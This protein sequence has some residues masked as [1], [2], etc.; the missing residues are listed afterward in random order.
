MFMLIKF[1]TLISCVIVLG[2]ITTPLLSYGEILG[3]INGTLSSKSVSVTPIFIKAIKDIVSVGILIIGILGILYNGSVNKRSLIYFLIFLGVVIPSI[4]WSLNNNIFIVI[5][6]IRWLVPLFLLGIFINYNIDDSIPGYRKSL[7]FVFIIHILAQ[8]YEFF[9]ASHYYGSFLN[10]FSLRNPGVFLIPST[11]A[12]FSV[13]F[14]VTFINVNRNIKFYLFSFVWLSL[15]L[16]VSGSGILTMLVINIF[17]V[18]RKYLSSFLATM[19][20]I[21][22]G[23]IFIPFFI[24]YSSLLG[25][26]DNYVE[27]SGG[28]RINIFLQLL[29]DNIF[30]SDKFGMGSNTGVIIANNL[31]I[32][33]NAMIVD[34]TF[35]SVLLNLSFLS[36]LLYVCF[37]FILFCFAI[38]GQNNKYIAMVFSLILFSFTSIWFEAYPYNTML[39]LLI[40]GMVGSLRYKNEDLFNNRKIR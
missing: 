2:I 26:G 12:M 10:S 14:Y 20:T 29:N 38:F 25:R 30:I 11:S 32:N 19:G 17:E 23:T 7:V 27:T 36:L 13:I 21:L 34:S 9:F 31:G 6:G 28:E 39:L 15:F 4:V 37:V 16:S 33:A 40:S 24:T 1:K 8:I 35:S 22:S 5:S 3:F 18:F